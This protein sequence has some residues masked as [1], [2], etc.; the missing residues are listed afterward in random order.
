M[1]VLVGC[2]ESQAACI[3]FRERGHEAYSCDLEPCSGGHPEWHI[4]AD[5]LTV[6]N[7]GLFV[8][9]TGRMVYIEKW[10]LAIFFPPCTFLTVTANRS[11]LNNPIRWEKRLAA[12]MFFHR[13]LN[14]GIPKI[15]IEN[16]KGVISTHIRKPDQYIQPYQ[17]GHKDSKMTGL[18]L[19]NLPLLKPTEI[20]EPEWVISPSGKRHSKTHWNSPSTNNPG[21]AKLRS[22]TYSG[23]ASAMAEQWG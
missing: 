10:D 3:A 18:W 13:L 21:N 9:Q 15:A 14:C 23:I 16:P 5:I 4:Q 8:T 2:E 1:R 19:K 11:F 22:K 7:G 6:N 17:F 12:V 20:V